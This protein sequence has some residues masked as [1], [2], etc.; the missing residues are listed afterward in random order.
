MMVSFPFF[1]P[2]VLFHIPIT[3]IRLII[4]QSNIPKRTNSFANSQQLS[5]QH[6]IYWLKY[7]YWLVVFNSKHKQCILLRP[8]CIQVW[9]LCVKISKIRSRPNRINGRWKIGWT[10]FCGY[11]FDSN[12]KFIQSFDKHWLL[13][14]AIFTPAPLPLRVVDGK[15]SFSP[16][17]KWQMEQVTK[18]RKWLR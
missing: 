3:W 7:C 11:D 13:K 1:L 15:I 2:M 10:G 6:K 16:F 18:Y 5:T 8:I 4:A 12:S 9:I 17:S 14:L